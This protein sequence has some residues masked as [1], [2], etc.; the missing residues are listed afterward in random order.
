MEIEIKEIMLHSYFLISICWNHSLCSILKVVYITC[1]TMNKTLVA[2]R[3][4]LGN[5][6]LYQQVCLWGLLGPNLY[7][8]YTVRTWMS[9][10]A[11]SK[12]LLLP[13]VTLPTELLLMLFLFT[14]SHIKNKRPAVFD[15]HLCLTTDC[16]CSWWT[17]IGLTL[18]CSAGHKTTSWQTTSGCGFNNVEGNYRIIM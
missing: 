5:M 6:V 18:A 1:R 16:C 11:Y 13:V 17:N 14:V 15:K 3:L 4:F 8:Q 7:I 9:L 2:L 12:M 10:S